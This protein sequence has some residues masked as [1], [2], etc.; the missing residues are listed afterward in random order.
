MSFGDPMLRERSGPRFNHK[1]QRL[2]RM[3]HLL[4]QD[5]LALDAL[6]VHLTAKARE[7]AA[8]AEGAV[9]GVNQDLGSPESAESDEH[10][11]RMEVS[12]RAMLQRFR[13][14][15]READ[16]LCEEE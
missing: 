12:I 1:V 14:D 3:V 7:M 15:L 2:M 10:F 16:R 9:D 11:M 6:H 8:E 4:Q 5:L 13:E